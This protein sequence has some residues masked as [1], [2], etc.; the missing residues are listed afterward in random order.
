MF[1]KPSP[2]PSSVAE[3]PLR[4]PPYGLLPR[5]QDHHLRHRSPYLSDCQGYIF[6]DVFDCVLD[7]VLQQLSQTTSVSSQVLVGLGHLVVYRLQLLGVTLSEALWDV[8]I[9]VFVTRR[10]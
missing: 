9:P 5:Y 2:V 6:S 1:L 3:V 4:R 8:T 10:W 7:E